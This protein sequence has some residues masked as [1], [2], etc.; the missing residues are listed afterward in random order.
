MNDKNMIIKERNS[1]LLTKGIIYLVL[2][3]LSLLVALI[4]Y[5]SDEANKIAPVFFIIGGLLFVTFATLF[6]FLLYKEF[7]PN[8][9]LIISSRGFKDLINVGDDII[10]EWTN[11]ASVKIL[12]KKDTPFLGV[13][14]ENSDIVIAKMKNSNADEM[15]ENINNNL[16][17]ILIS[18]AEV[19]IS[20]KEL[21]DIFVKFVREARI[22]SNDN[23]PKTKNNPFSTDD[24]LRVF[25]KLPKEENLQNHESGTT[26][27]ETPKNKTMVYE[28]PEETEETPTESI[29]TEEKQEKISVPVEKPKEE[30][31]AEQQ[32]NN[33]SF[34]ET[35]QRQAQQTKEPET[36]TSSVP[37]PIIDIPADIGFEDENRTEFREESTIIGEG[38]M[39]DEIRDLLSRAKS[40]KITEIEKIL[41]EKNVSF[42]PPK[43]KTEE[44]DT[45]HQPD[46]SEEDE[47]QID[48]SAVFTD[49]EKVVNDNKDDLEI[50][51][52]NPDEASGS[53]IAKEP[54]T[55][56]KPKHDDKT[57]TKEYYPDLVM[58]SDSF[59]DES[60]IEDDDF[61]IPDPI[62]YDEEDNQ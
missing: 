29:T 14:L 54:N 62:E 4:P 21:K 56:E 46:L 44:Q 34:Y 2:T 59:A 41:N 61:I 55:K 13:T 5:L 32:L 19:R 50:I 12:G 23:A 11:V 53:T 47:V 40:K 17:N 10:I 31:K 48:L 18:Q 58:I 8:D 60:E 39:S 1:S 24:V 33:D 22:L 16:P 7:H 37:E 30:H 36:D 49:D 27:N 51:I 26:E 43:S 42:I 9:A 57:D 45:I 3:T 6:V 28:A 38:E 52:D 15:R 25:G 20:I 35:L